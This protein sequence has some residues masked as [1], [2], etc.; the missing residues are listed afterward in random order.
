MLCT[1]LYP[2]G[3]VSHIVLAVCLKMEIC[4]VM[5]FLGGVR[6]LSLPVCLCVLVCVSPPPPTHR[7]L[8]NSFRVIEDVEDGAVEGCIFVKDPPREVKDLLE[9]EGAPGIKKV[10]V[11]SLTPCGPLLGGGMDGLIC[12]APLPAPC[13]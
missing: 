6:V 13:R 4:R 1:S 9:K 5:A 2:L 3:C 10:G 7:E 8:P 12:T 11:H